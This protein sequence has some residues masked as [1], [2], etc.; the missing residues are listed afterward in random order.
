[1]EAN[2]EREK[3]L[4][5]AAEKQISKAEK[6]A[7]SM[8]KI[9][10]DLNSCTSTLVALPP[11][12]LGMSLLKEAAEVQVDIS[13]KKNKV[14]KQKLELN[15]LEQRVRELM[16]QEE[17]LLKTKENVQEG[18]KRLDGTLKPKIQVRFR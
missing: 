4:M 1:M 6:Q 3:K 13:D 11:N 7:A 9:L 18:I 8:A 16:A 10:N 5:V 14:H 15:R 17:C 2:L 12:R